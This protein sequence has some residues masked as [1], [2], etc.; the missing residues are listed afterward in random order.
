[1]WCAA[2]SWCALC[3]LLHGVWW[4][5]PVRGQIHN[6]LQL[7]KIKR[8]II[9]NV[10]TI[11]ISNLCIMINNSQS[12]ILKICFHNQLQYKPHKNSIL[13]FFYIFWVSEFCCTKV[14][15]S[16]NVRVSSFLSISISNL[17][18]PLMQK[19]TLL[20]S[21]WQICDYNQFGGGVSFYTSPNGLVTLHHVVGNSRCNSLTNFHWSW[22]SYWSLW[23]DLWI[24]L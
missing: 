9:T 17:R 23:T 24:I 18:L 7:N 22:A 8:H 6:Q 16:W 5:K 1:M 14:I 13:I 4:I 10:L 12:I 3:G 11:T 2:R 19:L 15:H 20:L 21:W